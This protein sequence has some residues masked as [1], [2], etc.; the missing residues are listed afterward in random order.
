[1]KPLL[2]CCTIILLAQWVIGQTIVSGKVSDNRGRPVIGASISIKNS[3][4]GGT[5][6]STGKFN[7][8]TTESGNQTIEVTSVGY[9]VFT[10][11]INLTGKKH[12]IDFRLRELPDELKAVVITAG[13]F[14]AGDRK[15]ATVLTSLDIVTTAS[16]NADITSAIRTLPG[17]QQI[18]ETEGLFVRGGAG[19]EAKTFIDGSLVNKP[20]YSSVPDIAQRGRFSPFLFKGTIFSSGG[21][22]AIYGQALSSALIL[23][24]IDLPEKSSADFGVS[25][26]GLN[27]GIQHLA[28]NKKSSWGLNYG[29][30]NLLPYFKVVKQ[31]PDYFRVPEY[32]TLEGNFRVKTKPG[33]MI[34]FYVNT[35]ANRLGLRSENIDSVGM[36]NA[37]SLKNLYLFTNFNWKEK[38]GKGWKIELAGS[39]SIN[40]D[41]IE[42]ALQD[43]ENKQQ[44]PTDEEILNTQNFDVRNNNKLAQIRFILEKKLSGISL[45]R[46]GSELMR[47][48]DGV[49]FSNPYSTGTDTRLKDLYNAVFA[50]TDV[51]LTN[52]LAAKI[53]TRFEYSSLLQESTIAPRISLA[54]RVGVKGQVSAAYGIFFQK[55]ENNFLYASKDLTYTKATH[56]IANYQRIAGDYTIRTEVFYKKYD[57]LIKTVPSTTNDGA[58]DAKGF[59]LFWRDRKTIK[60]MDYWVSYSWLDTRRNYL[61][62]PF[63]AQPSFA[64]NHTASLVIKKFVTKLKTNLNASYTFA[65]G[66]PYY[67][68]NLNESEFLSERTKNYNSLSL[69]AN[70]LPRIGKKTNTF[71]VWVLSVN[72]VLNADLVYNYQY[73][74]RLKNAAGNF[75]AHPVKPPAKQFIFLGCFISIGTDRTEDVINSN[76]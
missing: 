43:Q 39:F 53:G 16:A 69:S 52:R 14:E 45:L 47:Y 4:D 31:K 8:I 46:F 29:Y 9:A 21:Y 37:F 38:L 22:S 35:N 76:L 48:H 15:R 3:Y 34:R 20:F 18:G 60:N 24:S 25:T 42:N 12:V 33:G 67:N 71:I 56:Y 50:E 10:D 75:I 23:E 68:P 6:D 61:D 5:S 11:S 66:R 57:D 65:T 41:D 73:S 30:A 62:F 44:F 70:Y 55:P 19:Y 72:N 54:Q 58:G 1:M 27:A 2:L 64:A 63:A 49:E 59:E 13:S 17:T 74:R 7:F 28:K 32:H 36:K 26:V 40:K 51:Y